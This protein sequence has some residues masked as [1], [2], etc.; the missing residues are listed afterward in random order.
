M[1]FILFIYKYHLAQI[2]ILFRD[3]NI[4]NN[5]YCLKAIIFISARIHFTF[6]VFNLE[7]EILSL[8][9]GSNI[10]RDEMDNNW[11]V[12]MTDISLDLIND[13]FPYLLILKKI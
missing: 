7:T 1:N 2:K 5:L 12:I 4:N 13:K 3:I 9:I 8:S 6:S 10:Y 11:Y